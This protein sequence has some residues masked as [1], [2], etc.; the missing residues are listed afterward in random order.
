MVLTVS[1]VLSP[2]TGLD[3]LR[4]RRNTLRQFSASIGAP[5][6]HDFTV[7]PR[8]ARPSRRS[9]HRIPPNVRDDGQRPSDRGGMARACRD[10]LPDGQSEIFLQKRLDRDGT[11]ATDLPVGQSPTLLRGAENGLAE[12][13][14]RRRARSGVVQR[15]TRSTSTEPDISF[16]RDRAGTCAKSGG[17]LC[18]MRAS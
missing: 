2:E 17:N 14:A 8:R 15:K 18:K 11:R 13:A 9:V 1:F 3:C 10:D 4:H 6:P 12:S 7:R 5:R 16:S